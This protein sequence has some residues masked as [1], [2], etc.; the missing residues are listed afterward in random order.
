MTYSFPCQD[1]SQAG[2]MKMMGRESGT[3]SG[4][5]WQV[6]RILYECKDND[7]LPQ[8][9]IMENVP[10]VCGVYTAADLPDL[11][12]GGGAVVVEPEL[13]MILVR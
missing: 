9:L 10:Q 5:L 7:S 11:L 3:R 8:V 4:L 6:E 12:F 2:K 13:T 1:L